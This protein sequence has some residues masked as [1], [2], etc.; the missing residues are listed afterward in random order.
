ML[1]LI[2]KTKN[3]HNKYPTVADFVGALT[4]LGHACTVAE[5]TPWDNKSYRTSFVPAQK[6]H[7]V[8]YAPVLCI[9]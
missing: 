9:R 1:W 6:G 7:G 2:F 4:S 3:T 8:I 5:V